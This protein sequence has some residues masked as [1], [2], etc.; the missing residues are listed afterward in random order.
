M[1][2]RSIPRSYRMMQGFGVNTFTLINAE[3][4][5]VFVKF[6]WLPE[7]G[8]HSLVWD[9]ALKIAGQDPDFHRKD[10]EEAI[11]NGAYPEWTLGVQ[12]IEEVD[13]HKFEFDI[14]DDTKIWPE[15]LVPLKKV[16]K[17][18]L[19]RTVDEF[20]P[21][22]E[23]VAFCTSHVVPGIG[24]SDDP[25]LQGRN[26][27]YFDT[28]TSRLGINWQEL[29]INRP[30]CPVFNFNKDGR[31]KHR[32]NASKVNYHPN[33]FE[34]IQPVPKEMGGYAF[35]RDRI[36]GIKERTR[37]PKFQEHFNQAQLFW[38]SMSGHEKQ[39]I[40]N[41]F[42]FELTHCDD[43]VVYQRMCERLRDVDFELARQVALNVGGPEPKGV[44]PNHG[45]VA[46]GLSQMEYIP[47]TPLIKGRRIA[48]LVADG[49]NST[50]VNEI[51]AAL[52]AGMATTWLIG[53]RR[54]TVYGAGETVK[55]SSGMSTD[56]SFESMRS[57]M[58]DAIII[59]SGHSHIA[60]IS[61]V[62]RV[63][64]WVREAFGHLKP[65]AAVGEGIAF[66]RDVV[67]LPGISYAV[68]GSNESVVDSYGVVTTNKLSLTRETFRLAK[69]DTT[70]IGKFGLTVS[71]HRNFQRELDGLV[72]RVPF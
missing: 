42:S 18:V 54:G 13:E 9:E 23:Q 66:L 30:V 5:R 62:G 63:V 2:D 19:N 7:L 50:E 51:R 28:Q 59:P 45:K 58:F 46:K 70:F 29:P 10:L 24:F 69:G 41:A 36:N 11:N 1:S 40:V 71:M 60:A 72:A 8:V 61:K 25:V 53:L 67:Q 47:E 27:S 32:I 38:N 39:H 64:H 49:F 16:G 6:H 35:H 48:I 44:R 65:I 34:E 31:M 21:E 26:F 55:S 14:L 57:T 12:I 4:K 68:E 22:T 15:D 56:H 52:K 20:F 37:G 33:R 3:S 43:P 17:L